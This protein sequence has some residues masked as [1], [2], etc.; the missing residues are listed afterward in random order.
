[1][2]AY[3]ETRDSP[4]GIAVSPD[5][6]TAWVANALDDSL[7]AH[8]HRQSGRPSTRVDLGGPKTLTKERWGERLFNNAKIAFQRQLSCHSC[9]PDG[10][11]DGLTY[12]I[13][14]DGIGLNPVDNRTLRGIYDTDPFKW[15]GTNDTLARQCGPRLAVFF[16]RVAP[17]TPDELQAVN[18]YTVTIPRPPNRYRPLGAELT[19]AQRRGRLVFERSR[20]A[21]G[22]EI[23][24][25][26][27]CNTCHFAPYYTDRT[28]R[29]IGSKHAPRHPREV[30]RAPSQQHLRLRAL[31]AQRHCQHPRG[32]LDALQPVRHPRRHQRSHQGSVERPHRVPEDALD[33]SQPDER[34]RIDAV[35]V[36][37]ERDDEESPRPLR[38]S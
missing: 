11:V 1:M 37:E 18:D 19:P 24:V 30:R 36:R 20:M 25:D 8:R 31:H 35:D 26:N 27:R 12:D 34:A 15:A 7:T 3:V 33:A 4:R 13:E 9:H 21:S 32:D 10:H 29:D 38:A 5:G 6:R 22:R 16:T 28:V 23:P 17:F 2:S 14:A